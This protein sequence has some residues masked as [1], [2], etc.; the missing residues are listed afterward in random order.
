MLDPI[1]KN[2]VKDLAATRQLLRTIRVTNKDWTVE[3]IPHPRKS[4]W[5][6]SVENAPH[7]KLSNQNNGQAQKNVLGILRLRRDGVPG[8]VQQ[9]EG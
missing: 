9:N 2:R 1:S 7:K 6:F 5:G 3:T 4:L 8:R